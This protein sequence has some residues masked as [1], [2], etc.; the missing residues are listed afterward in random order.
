MSATLRHS[1]THIVMKQLF[2]FLFL[3]PVMLQAGRLGF[4]QM[5]NGD[6]IEVTL[7]STGCFHDNTS[8][9]EVRKTK[10]V[11]Q[12]TEY[13]ITWKRLPTPEMVEKKVLGTLTLTAQEVAGL[14]ALLEFYRGKKSVGSTTTVSLAVE[15]H[16]P[17][18]LVGVEKLWDESGGWGLESSKDLVTFYQL[19]RRLEGTASR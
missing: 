17:G 13:R 2:A 19:S 6:R 12:F 3:L 9:Y 14:D 7:R 10:G 5:E 11:Y 18:G 15:Y 8:Y 4:S 16:E 1:R